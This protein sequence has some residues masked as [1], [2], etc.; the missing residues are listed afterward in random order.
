MCRTTER[1][2]KRGF[3]GKSPKTFHNI[4]RSLLCPNSIFILLFSWKDASFAVNRQWY[5][6]RGR[7]SK[8]YIFRLCDG[9]LNMFLNPSKATATF[10]QSTRTQSFLKTILTLSCW[11]SL[12]SSRWALRWVPMCQGFNHFPSFFLSFSTDQV[13]HHQHKGY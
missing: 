1:P 13:S 12:D 4:L 10:I 8:Q 9:G 5:Q 11:Y 6:L 3:P 2:R 7:N